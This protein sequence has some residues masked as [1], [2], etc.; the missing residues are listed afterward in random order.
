MWRVYAI[1]R[2]PKPKTV[3]LSLPPL[4]HIFLL[5]SSPGHQGLS[6]HID[7]AGVCDG[8]HH[9]S[10]CGYVS[11]QLSVLS[12]HHTKQT[13]PLPSHQCE[14]EFMSVQMLML[15]SYIDCIIILQAVLMI[16]VYATS[17]QSGL[18][19]FKVDHAC[20]GL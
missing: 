1:C 10:G 4:C 9:H 20:K 8:G 14:H 13:G 12:H 11:G 2:N 7:S 6:P 15:H 17:D 3:S 19:H 16:S 5:S 18:T